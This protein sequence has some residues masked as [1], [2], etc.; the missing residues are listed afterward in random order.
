MIR[1]RARQAG[2][3]TQIGCHPFRATG[4]TTY[5]LNGDSM[6]HARQLAARESACSTRLCD[7]T[8]DEIRID[9]IDRIQI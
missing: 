3:A 4:I 6:E 9:E 8:R 5:L 1:P 2:I 7:R